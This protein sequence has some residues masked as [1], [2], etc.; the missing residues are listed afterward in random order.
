MKIEGRSHWEA[1]V[2]ALSAS[3]LSRAEY[4]RQHSVRYGQLHRWQV[5]LGKGGLAP[6]KPSSFVRARP[7]GDTKGAADVA[8]RLPSMRLVVGK[9]TFFEFPA[10]SDPQ[11]VAALAMALGGQTK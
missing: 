9:N 2:K 5:R 10:S 4:C 3:G 7:A 8:P 1:H 11:W 6:R